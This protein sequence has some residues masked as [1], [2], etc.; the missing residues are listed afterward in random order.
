MVHFNFSSRNL[1]ACNMPREDA[2]KPGS[3]PLPKGNQQSFQYPNEA[4]DKK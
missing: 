4:E 3:W 1:L 2:E